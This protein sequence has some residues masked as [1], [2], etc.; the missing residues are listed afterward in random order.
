MFGIG[1]V[2]L[3]VI[4]IVA[5]VFVGPKK[6][7]DM[8]R[9]MGKFFVQI[10]RMTSDVK[11]TMDDVIRDAEKE[12]QKEELDK[13]R[14]LLPKV[15]DLTKDIPDLKASAQSLKTE[16]SSAL[17][18]QIAP[19]TA[20]DPDSPGKAAQQDE[21]DLHDPSHQSE[22]DLHDPSHRSDGDDLTGSQSREA[23]AD[24]KTPGSDRPS[25]DSD[26]GLE[27]EKDT[28]HQKSTKVSSH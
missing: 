1:F 9:Q 28:D 27:P 13:I 14:D 3:C 22:A 25:F 12:I 15:T 21:A 18:D 2:E 23:S 24:S 4:V 5:L 10:R 26:L 17:D 7:P 16:L 19:S 11:N 20:K 6:L 8:M